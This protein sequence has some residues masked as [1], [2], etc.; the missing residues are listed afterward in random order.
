MLNVWGQR[1]LKRN[2]AMYY[3]MQNNI[4]HSF[5]EIRH[6]KEILQ[7]QTPGHSKPAN[8]SLMRFNLNDCTSVWYL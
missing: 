6:F 5:D 1:L 7:S 2:I 4:S 8:G 3:I